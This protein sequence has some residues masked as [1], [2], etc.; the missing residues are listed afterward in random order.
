[1][2]R[3]TTYSEE[4]ADQICERL[5]DAESLRSICEDERMPSRTTV[6]RWMVE[7][8]GFGAKCARAR[9]I[10]ADTLFDD[11]QEVA[12]S[13]NPDDV[14]RA[15]LRVAAMQWR[16]SKLAPKKYGEKLALAGDDENPVKVV[17]RIEREIV[18]PPNP[19]R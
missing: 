15:K 10:Q 11:I 2:A 19:D 18:R 6:H 5:M 8:E 3:P 17:T 16:A 7:I 4:I 9:E 1:M 12:D 13:G 14:Q